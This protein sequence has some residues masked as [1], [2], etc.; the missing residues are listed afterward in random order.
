MFFYRSY[1][2]LCSAFFFL[3][4]GDGVAADITAAAAV[5]VERETEEEERI[6]LAEEGFPRIFKI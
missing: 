2:V 5:N 6:R 1:F 3:Q 4:A